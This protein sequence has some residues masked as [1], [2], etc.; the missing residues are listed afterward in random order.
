MNA[1]ERWLYIAKLEAENVASEAK[2]EELIREHNR[3]SQKLNDIS[4]AVVIAMS[5]FNPAIL[6]PCKNKKPH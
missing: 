2:Q 5:I 4:N 3:K 6:G 1:E